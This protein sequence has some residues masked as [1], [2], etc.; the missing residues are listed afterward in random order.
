MMIQIMIIQVKLIQN[1]VR[2]WLLRKNYINLREATKMLQLAWREKKKQHFSSSAD[3]S[4]DLASRHRS[5]YLLPTSNSN[6][7]REP[8]FSSINSSTTTAITTL[9]AAT[10]GMI[11]RKAFD[12][13]R[14][15]AMSSLA[16]Q[17]HLIS[18]TIPKV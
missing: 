3:V 13:V 2:C 18:K 12:K 11:A 7:S 4:D 15:Q 8:G 17:K 16:F 1:N 9:Q 14:A 5:A 10:R 6:S